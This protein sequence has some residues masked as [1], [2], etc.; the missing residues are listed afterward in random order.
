M[1]RKL[2]RRIFAG[3]V[4]LLYLPVFAWA[5]VSMIE[6]Y[7]N[8]GSFRA[9]TD[10]GFIGDASRSVGGALAV[11]VHG[12][13]VAGL[14]VQTSKV[15]VFRSP[16]NFYI[17]RRTIVLPH[18]L[19]RWGNPRAYFFLGSGAGAQF[20][21]TVWRSDNFLPDHTPPDW[22]EVKPRVFEFKDSET[23]RI[24]FAPKTGFAVFPSKHLGFRLDLYMA[25]WNMGARIGA[26]F[27]F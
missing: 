1:D 12:G 22:R 17:T 10:E 13:V 9:G 6:F 20:E 18:L 15:A 8:I 25:S 11:A 7:G 4:V 19:Y 2:I 14:D 3:I 16:D 23:S 26:G 5:Q 27:R 24:L 21:S